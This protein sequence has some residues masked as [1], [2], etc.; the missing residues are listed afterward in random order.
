[1][2]YWDWGHM[3]VR[4]QCAAVGLTLLPHGLQRLNLNAG[5]QAWAVSTFTHL[6]TQP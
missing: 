5:G 3:K 6:P 1:M 2:V 4:K